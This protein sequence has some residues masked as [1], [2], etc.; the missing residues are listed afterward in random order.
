[1]IHFSKKNSKMLYGLAVL[2]MLYHHLFKAPAALHCTFYSTFDLLGLGK[3]LSIETL[4]WLGKLCVAI[5]AFISGYAMCKKAQAK[6]VII[7]KRLP[8][9]FLL[10]VKQLIDFMIKYWLVFI[11]F[12]PILYVTQDI[13]IS[14]AKELLLN[15]VGVE[16]SYNGA[17]WYVRQYI[18][19]LLLF[20]FIDFIY[21]HINSGERPKIIILGIVITVLFLGYY[22]SSGPFKVINVLANSVTVTYLI[23]FIEGYFSARLCSFEKLSNFLPTKYRKLINV[24]ILL[25]CVAIR[26][27]LSTEAGYC[28]IDT[29]IIFPFI[30]SVCSIVENRSVIL[31]SLSKVGE[32]SV[33]MWLVH[34]FY[35]DGGIVCDLLTAS[36]YSLLIYVTLVALSF[37]TAVILKKIENFV[38]KY[39][40][41]LKYKVTY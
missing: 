36:H 28:I 11:V 3:V 40:D 8:G 26:V 13:K 15:F 19:M 32:Y 17:W 6:S 27:L 12:I 23:I 30:Y 20:P 41:K 35:L 7:K 38:M 29:L 39:F 21:E 4:A 22:Y 14:S 5:Y 18:L 16:F 10:V 24:M 37:A 33:Y 2:M 31:N 25:C 1:M 9:N 34:G